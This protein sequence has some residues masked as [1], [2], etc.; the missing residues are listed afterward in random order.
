MKTEIMMGV[1]LKLTQKRLGEELR[2]T[3]R[4]NWKPLIVV[5]KSERKK[6]YNVH[7]NHGQLTS[8]S[9]MMPSKTKK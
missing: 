3:D 8:T 6:N 9:I 1:A 2:A 7:G 5:R 4:R